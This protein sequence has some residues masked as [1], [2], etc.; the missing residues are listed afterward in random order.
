[1][2]PQNILVKVLVI[3]LLAILFGSP[4]AWGVPQVVRADTGPALEESTVIGSMVSPY[5]FKP[6]RVRMVDEQVRLKI[7]PVKRSQLTYQQVEVGADFNLFNTS[8]ITESMQAVF[9]MTDLK[10]PWVVGPGSWTYRELAVGEATF[11]VSID[12]QEAATTPITTTTVIH[13]DFG[14][15]FGM[16]LECRTQWKQFGITFPPHQNVKIQVS[17]SMQ[18]TFEL[19]EGITGYPWDSFTYI[20]KTGAP[21]YGSIG[22]VDISMELP[23][24]VQRDQILKIP[25]GYHIQQNTLY[26]RWRNLEPDQNFQVVIMSSQTRQDLAQAL[27]QVNSKPEDAQAWGDLAKLYEYLAWRYDYQASCGSTI[28][29]PLY[30]EI[31]NWEYAHLAMQAYQR[32]LKLHPKDGKACADYANLLAEMSLS[33]NHGAIMAGYPSVQFA[34]GEFKRAL[35]LE[36]AERTQ[37]LLAG[38]EQCILKSMSEP[39][40]CQCGF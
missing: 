29:Y 33:G 15:G 7:I 6:T 28:E 14:G 25:A 12:G 4:G 27:M 24:P 10:C 32:Q 23:E 31:Y 22:Q 36:P 21:W 20:L 19:G 39:P 2:K 11:K 17:Y 5:K 30:P 40:A 13:Q 37:Q 16:D 38:F 34:L 18:P 9:P 3:G 1:M 35:A 8:T 26:W